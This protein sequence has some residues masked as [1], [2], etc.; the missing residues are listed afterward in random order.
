[1]GGVRGCDDAPLISLPRADV[2]QPVQVIMPYYDNPKMLAYQ[3]GRWRDLPSSLRAHLS[4]ILVDDGSPVTP[5]EAVLRDVDLSGIESLRLFRIDVDVRWNWLAAR[6]IGW[7]HAEQGFCVVTDI[8]HVIPP[9]TFDALIFGNFDPKVIYRF[10]RAEHNGLALKPHPNSWFMTRT[11]FWKVGGYDEAFSG[12]YGTD[13]EYRRRCVTVAPIRILK[14][15]LI[16]HEFFMD[17][18]TTRYKRKQPEDAAVSR[19][20]RARGKDWK[21]RTLTFPY[22]E[23][24]LA[25]RYYLQVG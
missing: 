22:R 19:I 15:K 5:A 6:N 10:S 20:V 25:D 16:R 7:H 13:G 14:D 23:I 21:P 11:M 24:S 4:F 1:M 18:S 8:D 2:P 17:S 9:D 3:V 12:H